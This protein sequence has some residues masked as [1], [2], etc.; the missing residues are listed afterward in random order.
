MDM[1]LDP[2]GGQ[3]HHFLQW[4]SGQDTVPNI[5][6]KERHIGGLDALKQLHETGQLQAKF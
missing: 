3:V 6:I 4:F 5:Y 1:D 2:E